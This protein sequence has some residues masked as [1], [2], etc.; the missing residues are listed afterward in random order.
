[1]GVV[2]SGVKARLKLEWEQTQ[3]NRYTEFNRH[4][5]FLKETKLAAFLTH[6]SLH[7]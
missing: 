5:E 1:M 6:S 7:T 4:I 2:E 3:N